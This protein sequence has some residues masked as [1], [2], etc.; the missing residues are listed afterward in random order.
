M[1]SS[2]S[3][4]LSALSY[5]RKKIISKS[6]QICILKIYFYFAKCMFIFCNITAHRKW[7]DTCIFVVNF[8]TFKLIHVDSA[9]PQKRSKND[10]FFGH[11][12][13]YADSYKYLVWS[14]TCLSGLISFLI[15]LTYVN[16]LVLIQVHVQLKWKKK[17]NL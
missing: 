16:I 13:L 11:M 14:G 5:N 12:H 10:F 15:V 7:I 6:N 8:Y 1:N 3:S 2:H 4:F 9:K 17:V